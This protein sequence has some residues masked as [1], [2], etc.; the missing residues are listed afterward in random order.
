VISSLPWSKKHKKKFG[1]LK[2]S[3]KFYNSIS[4]VYGS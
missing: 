3:L 1:G 4:S 2:S